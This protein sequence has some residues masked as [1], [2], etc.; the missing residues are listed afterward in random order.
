[1]V[2]PRMNKFR[3]EFKSIYCSV[4]KPEMKKV[5]IQLDLIEKRYES[6]IFFQKLQNI[7]AYES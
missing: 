1:M 2:K 3:A 6:T 5:K 7:V 4:D